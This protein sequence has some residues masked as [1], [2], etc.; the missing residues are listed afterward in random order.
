M[1]ITAILW[2]INYPMFIIELILD[3]LQHWDGGCSFLKLYRGLE[4]CQV[5]PFL[6]KSPNNL[7][8]N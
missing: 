6:F 4:L 8:I 5:K 1:I 3:D 2:G 7:L